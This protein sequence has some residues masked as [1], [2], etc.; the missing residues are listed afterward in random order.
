MYVLA[1]GRN[2]LGARVV[3]QELKLANPQITPF[4]AGVGDLDGYLRPLGKPDAHFVRS[5]DIGIKNY[6]V[7]PLPLFRNDVFNKFA[8]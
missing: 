5:A 3:H 6:V 7:M 8:A 2:N 1:A 4:A